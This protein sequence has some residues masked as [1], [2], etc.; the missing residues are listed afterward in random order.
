MENF[1]NSQK[2]MQKCEIEF[3]G[4][5][6]KQHGV[7]LYDYPEVAQAKQRYESYVIPGRNGEL[8]RKENAMGNITISCTF[9]VIADRFADRIRDLKRWLSGSGKL[10]LSEAPDYF[11]NVLLVEHE[12]I[13]RE[14]KK[15]GRFTVAFVCYPYEF[16]KDG[17]EE[18][19]ISELKYNPYDG[20]KP[21]YRIKGNGMCTLSV[22]GKTMRANVGQNLNI[23]TEMMTAYR[24]DGTI[25]NTAVTGD[26][27]NLW[28]KNGDNTISLTSGF[29]LKIVPRWGYKA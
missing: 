28:L 20:C 4:E 29:Q 10:T 5:V 19:N 14:V 1:F 11:Y 25:M 18:Y 24:S 16:R 6:G 9:S 8:I 17:M 21:I 26:Y 13:E 12:G 22:N 15:Y 7:F 27:E 3:K 23:D 2:L